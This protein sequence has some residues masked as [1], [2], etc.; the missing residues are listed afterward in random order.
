MTI[1]ILTGLIIGVLAVTGSAVAAVEWMEC[2]GSA[3]PH[4]CDPA[5]SR[6]ELVVVVPRIG[7]RSAVG[8]A[9]FIPRPPQ[10]VVL[11]PRLCLAAD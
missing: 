4:S 11:T 3:L 5:K 9:N 10:V 6:G 2:P 7:G 1:K 8:A